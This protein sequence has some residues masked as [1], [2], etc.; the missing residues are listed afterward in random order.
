MPEIYRSKPNGYKA[1]P[2]GYK[3]KNDKKEKGEKMTH[4]KGHVTDLGK[5]IAQGDENIYR[6]PLAA[7]YLLPARLNFETK[8]RKEK[9]VLMVRKHPITNIPWLLITAALVFFPSLLVLLPTIADLPTQY[10]LVVGM[11]WYLIVIAYVIESFLSW[12]YDVNIVT[13]ERV[14]DIDFHNLI[15]KQ[16]A[17]AKLDKVQDITYNQGGVFR[18]L[19][20]Y[21]NVYIQTAAEVPAFEFEAVPQPDKIVGI[22]RDLILEE[23]Q[24][25]VEGR[26]R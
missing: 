8:E 7:F 24:E 25:I 2:D 20:N 14:V 11:V 3:A 10:Q 19:F 13:D 4:K 23:E 17:D 22:I 1:K 15:Y 21:G 16:V 12:F 6:N 18:T 5:K 9:V 26:V